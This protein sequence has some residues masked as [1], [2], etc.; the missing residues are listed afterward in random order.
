[1]YVHAS[2][3]YSFFN[4]IHFYTKIEQ[5]WWTTIKFVTLRIEE[6]N[7]R[8]SWSYTSLYNNNIHMFILWQSS[9]FWQ[10]SCNPW[11]NAFKGQANSPVAC[12]FIKTAV[13][14]CECSLNNNAYSPAS[15]HYNWSAVFCCS[16]LALNFDAIN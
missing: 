12:L 11:L 14:T 4:M 6:W 3:F 13:A 9:K 16:L 10:I 8:L 5:V 1:M 2:T 7:W 15:L